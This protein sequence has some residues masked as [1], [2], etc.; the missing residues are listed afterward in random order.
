M[1]SEM[2]YNKS[3]ILPAMLLLWKKINKDKFCVG[4][5]KIVKKFPTN[6]GILE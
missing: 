6:N 4:L 1:F 5:T 2:L 3:K